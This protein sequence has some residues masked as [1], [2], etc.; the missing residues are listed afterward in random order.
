MHAALSTAGSCQASFY[1]YE[2][3]VASAEELD[4][5]VRQRRILEAFH[6]TLYSACL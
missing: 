2:C 1:L 3:L 5:G 4:L 6:L